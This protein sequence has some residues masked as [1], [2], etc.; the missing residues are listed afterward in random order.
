[1]NSIIHQLQ[2]SSPCRA[3]IYHNN[4]KHNNKHHHYNNH[5]LLSSSSSFDS[6]FAEAISKPLP[7]W[8]KQEK[9]Q[10]EQL[11]KD[12]ESNRERVVRDFKAKYDIDEQTKI[13]EINKKWALIEAK[14][15]RIKSSKKK[16]SSS[17]TPWYKKVFSNN[18]DNNNDKT[19]DNDDNEEDED[20]WKSFWEDEQKSTGFYLPGFSEVFPELKLKWPKWARRKDGQALKCEKDEDCQFPQAC[21]PHPIIPGDK[22]CC[23]G[24]GQRIMS[25]SYQGREITSNDLKDDFNGFPEQD[26]GNTPQW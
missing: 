19:N 8:Y 10:Q 23:T 15:N 22:F 14:R 1:M 24:W 13:E 7:E 17:N 16:N 25:P 2:P 6:D 3:R 12:I 11:Q 5:I 4:N 21:C 26:K 9:Q 18:D 20:E